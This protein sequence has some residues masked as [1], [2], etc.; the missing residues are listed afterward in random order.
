VSV[1]QYS[2][3]EA[4]VDIER[5]AIANNAEAG[6]AAIRSTFFIVVSL[7]E[8]EVFSVNPWTTTWDGWEPCAIGGKK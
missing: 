2:P 6:P 5:N 1:W 4:G 3:A 8:Y 7:V